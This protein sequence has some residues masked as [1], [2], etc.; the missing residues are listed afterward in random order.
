[1]KK[2]A[3]VVK[4]YSKGREVISHEDSIDMQEE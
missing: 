2:F 1:M 4:E 3:M